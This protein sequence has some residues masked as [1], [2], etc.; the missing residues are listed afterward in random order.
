M[1]EEELWLAMSGGPDL[2]SMYVTYKA[3][4]AFKFDALT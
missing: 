2:S 4:M 1:T 3:Y